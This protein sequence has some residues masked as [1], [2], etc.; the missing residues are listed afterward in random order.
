MEISEKQNQIL[1]DDPIATS[2]L[3]EVVAGN[4]QIYDMLV[5]T[6]TE[7]VTNKIEEK[8]TRL[9][10]NLIGVLSVLTTFII[11]AG[12]VL[13][14]VFLNSRV[15]KAVN[16]AMEKNLLDAKF[17][18]DLASVNF[19]V[20][21]MTSSR[22]YSDDEAKRLIS[23]LGTLYS[24]YV[25][26]DNRTPSEKQKYK[27]KLLYATEKSLELF[28]LSGRADFISQLNGVANFA[29]IASDSIQTT[30]SEFYGRKLIGM[31]GAPEIWQTKDKYVQE[32]EDY[33]EFVKR[34]KESGY[35]EL[36][37]AFE[38][39]VRH[40]EKRPESELLEIIKDAETMNEKDSSGFVTIMIDHC[41]E[42]FTKRP[43]AES[44][45]VSERFKEFVTTYKGKSELIQL[46]DEQVSA[47]QDSQWLL[48]SLI[49]ES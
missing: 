42:N 26:D 41:L 35:P 27:E 39:I 24:I 1:N 18:P 5:S 11:I 33:K 22:G 47:A 7:R 15:E 8:M 17:H 32:R 10:N 45:R 13:F 49:D 38:L 2:D 46:I 25:K 20:I 36:F 3:R 30:L 4:E 23:N 31:P 43:D 40:M 14:G 6:I 19:D 44:R 48:D 12:S 9:Q 37:N 28:A 21:R 29:E 34:A 16:R